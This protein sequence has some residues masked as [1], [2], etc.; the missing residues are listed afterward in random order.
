[1]SN[2]LPFEAIYYLDKIQILY[3]HNT[4][5]TPNPLQKRAG[6]KLLEMYQMSTIL[7]TD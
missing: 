7:K 4:T 2:F 3:L 5:F 6:A 1:M